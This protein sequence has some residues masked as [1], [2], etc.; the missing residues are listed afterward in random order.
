M[1]NVRNK[2]I[3]RETCWSTLEEREVLWLMACMLQLVSD[4]KKGVPLCERKHKDII[5]YDD[6]R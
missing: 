1:G 6:G 4:S 2:L 5:N 3:R